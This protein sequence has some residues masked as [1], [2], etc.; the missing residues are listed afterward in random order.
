MRANPRQR[1]LC[2]TAFLAALLFARDPSLPVS[3]Q[4]RPIVVAA[5]I[6]LKESFSELGGIYERRTGT[7]VTFTFGASGELAK[8]IEA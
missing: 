8:Q 1:R 2:V 4:N 7:K 6:S 5:A 3:A